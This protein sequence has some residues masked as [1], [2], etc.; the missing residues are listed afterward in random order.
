MPF[1]TGWRQTLRRESGSTPGAPGWRGPLEEQWPGIGAYTWLQ[2]GRFAL[3]CLGAAG[4]LALL[5]WRRQLAVAALIALLAFDLYCFVDKFTPAT[6]R[7][8]LHVRAESIERI[9]RDPEWPRIMSLGEDFMHR[10]APNTPMIVGLEDIQ[11]SDSLEVGAYRRLLGACFSE[12]LGYPQPNPTLPVIDLLGVKYVISGVELEG[13]P[14][15]S[16]A[17]TY[18]TWLYVNEEA[19]PRA[20]AVPRCEVKRTHAE[21]LREVSSPD[22]APAATAIFV[23]PHAPS[24]RPGRRLPVAEA[25]LTAHAPDSAVVEG[26]FAGGELLVLTDAYYPGWRAFQDGRECRILRADYALRAV[27]I[28]QPCREVRFVYQPASFAV[29]AFASLIA[30]SLLAAIGAYSLAAS[31]RTEAA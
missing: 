26:D 22:F 19:L 25:G 28:E 30:L 17:S 31:R 15:L 16:L 9:H 4:F 7:E 12:E 27:E 10:M 1:S 8:Y 3:L 6:P 21:A 5:T 13:V 11:G 23:E 20:F 2:I 24:S 29:G 14:G 18:D